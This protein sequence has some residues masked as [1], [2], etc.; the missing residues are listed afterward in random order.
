MNRLNKMNDR[1]TISL[2]KTNK[3]KLGKM[4]VAGE[5]YNSLISRLLRTV[6][7]DEIA[8]DIVKGN[9]PR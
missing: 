1:T 4:G 5:S 8:L 3:Y 6:Q 9:D 7:L 2:S